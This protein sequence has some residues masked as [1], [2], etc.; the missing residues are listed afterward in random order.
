[1]T[2]EGHTATVSALALSTDGA[3]LYS[4]SWDKTIRMWDVESGK[5]TGVL[6]GHEAAVWALL[7][8]PGGKLLTGSAD[9]TIKLWDTV[10]KKMMGEL[11]G[12]GD[13]VRSLVSCGDGGV[14][15]SAGNDCSLK[16]WSLDLAG[17]SLDTS[18]GFCLEVNV[19]TSQH[20]MHRPRSFGTDSPFLCARN[21]GCSR[22]LFDCVF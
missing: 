18:C 17:N 20:C 1:M 12:H 4:G 13:C 16:F 9:R 8:M 11:R 22:L 21:L 10:E 19:V 14:F 5:C 3:T 15:A 6:E 7:P 2:L